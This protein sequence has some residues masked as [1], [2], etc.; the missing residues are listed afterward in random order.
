M[1]YHNTSYYQN[2]WRGYW[3]RKH[4]AMGFVKCPFIDGQYRAKYGFAR[5][6]QAAWRGVLG[7]RAMQN[8]I[9]RRRRCHAL[10]RKIIGRGRPIIIL[11]SLTRKIQKP[12]RRRLR[13]RWLMK[14][15]VTI[16]CMFRKTKSREIYREHLVVRTTFPPRLHFLLVHISS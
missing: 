3:A 9:T 10:W 4:L 16:Q 6:I 13:E 7:R 12:Y 14:R 8:F 5:K 15:I 11:G 1:S 2:R